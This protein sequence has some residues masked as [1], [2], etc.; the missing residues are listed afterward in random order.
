MYRY[1]GGIMKKHEVNELR[2]YL[3]SRL[4]YFQLIS[5]LIPGKNG[6]I[7]NQLVKELLISL[8][9]AVKMDDKSFMKKEKDL[10][11][12]V[13]EIYI[14]REKGYRPKVSLVEISSSFNEL[15]KDGGDPYRYGIMYGWLENLIDCSSIPCPKD[16]PYHFKL[17]I[18][19][20]AG[21]FRIEEVSLLGD[22]FF[23]LRFAEKYYNT[24]LEQKDKYEKNNTPLEEEEAVYKILSTY[25]GAIGTYARLTIINFYAFVEILVNSIGHDFYM[26]NQK[27]L[28]EKEAEI[29][30]GKK[31][32]N[33]VSL[34]YKIEKFQEII[35]PDKRATVKTLDEKQRK[36]PFI[37]FINELK[38]LRDAS[39]HYS[40]NKVEILRQP[41]DWIKDARQA[42]TLCLEVANSIWC[43]CYPGRSAPEY[44][45]SLSYDKLISIADERIQ[46]LNN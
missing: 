44:L 25:N 16:V 36:E 17:G 19:P 30:Q 46:L 41:G 35:R 18:G 10:R 38:Q 22:A 27:S 7:T 45:F 42:A 4:I 21:N 29:L 40:P 8:F 14:R 5:S 39:M 3:L 34:E 11:K 37:T 13:D 15:F 31:N 43:S 9:D 23:C 12:V 24:L 33:F 26:R 28:L 1:N 32:G 2:E 20:H 6:G